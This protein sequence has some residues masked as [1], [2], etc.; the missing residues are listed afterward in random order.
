MSHT[1]LWVA[2]AIIALV[3]IVGFVLSVPHARDVAETQQA[4]IAT[5]TP[6]ITILDSYKKG[7]HTIT[8][9][10]EMPNACAAVS[11]EAH[12]ATGDASSTPSIL[13]ALTMVDDGGICLQLPTTATFKTT[14][15]TTTTRLPL[16][17]TINGTIATTTTP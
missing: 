4:S 8:G 17:V 14:V 7:T 6:K 9:S 13:I 5:T 2:A 15:S 3:V 10:V 11:A 16:V 12:I 1:R